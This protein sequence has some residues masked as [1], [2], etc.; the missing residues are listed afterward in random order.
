M[1]SFLPLVLAAALLCPGTVRAEQDSKS[2]ADEILKKIDSAI[3]EESAKSREAILDLV[4]QELRGAKTTPADPAGKGIPPA[5][6]LEKAKAVLTVDLLKKHATY[7]AS[8]ELEGRCAGYAGCNKAADYIAEQFKGAGLR[9]GGDAG[10]WFQ[11]F[12]LMGKDTQ[13]VI[14]VI[15]GTDPDLRSE[16]VVIGAHYDHVGTADTRDFGRMGGRGDDSIWNGADDNGSGTTCVIALA[17]AFGRSGLSARRTIVFLCFSGE[18]AG[19]VGSRYYTNHPL[20]A[21]EKHAFMLNLDMVG[22]NP[23]KAMEIHGVGSAEGGVIRKAVESAVA[24]SGLK[25]KLNDAVTLIGGDSDHSSFADKRVPYAFFFSGFH[26]D[27]HRPSD[28]ADKLAYD[29]MVK[30]AATSMDI[31]LALGNADEK[32]KFSGR[33]K[34]GLTLPDLEP[35]TPPRRL[36]VTVQ[37]LDDADCDALKLPADQGGLRVDGVQ[38]GG[39]ADGAGIK[40]GDVV[41]EVSGTTLPRGGTR[42]ELRKVLTDK[43][44]PGKDTEIVVL[45]K[46]ERV[47][48]TAKWPE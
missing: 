34:P 20:A 22:R 36:G 7:L 44:R 37:E 4:R 28:H 12:R 27:Y 17:Q 5:A 18:E 23:T 42:D 29:N 21:L 40:V 48:L 24:A 19:L 14:G 30:V 2:R 32:P 39:A 8:D 41:L 13:N 11:K 35:A 25:A 38:G 45:R 46:G 47:T 26:A 15:D 10:G 3:Q 33:A 31:L 1:R 9:P 16:I 43:V 6:A